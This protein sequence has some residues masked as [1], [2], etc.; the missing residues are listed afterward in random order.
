MTDDG[1]DVV[2]WE[3]PA[4]VIDRKNPRIELDLEP[5]GVVVDDRPPE[6]A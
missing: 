5:I 4:Q 3:L 6:A 1:P 2:E